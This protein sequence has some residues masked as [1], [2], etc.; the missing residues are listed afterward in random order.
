MRTVFVAFCLSLCVL[1]AAAAPRPDSP[2][3][4]VFALVIPSAPPIVLRTCSD[5]GSQNA[6]IEYRT[7]G[8]PSVAQKIPGQL[9]VLNITCSRGLSDD[10]S[11]AL[12]RQV[13]ET[14][15]GTFR[16]DGAL[17]LYDNARHE[18]ARWNL[19]NAWPAKLTVNVDEASGVAEETVLL[20]VERIERP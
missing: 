2:A 15:G 10:K 19:Y 4:H 13:V 1:P 17:V 16:K 5:I 8:D 6:I 12:W 14:T 18:V 7:G 20:A 3:A 11:L 9:S